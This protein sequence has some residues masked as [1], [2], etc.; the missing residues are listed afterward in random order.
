VKA[1]IIKAR[2]YIALLVVCVFLSVLLTPAYAANLDTL[3]KEKREKQQELRETKTQIKVQKKLE[4]NVLGELSQLDQ[5]IDAVERDLVG[6]RSKEQVASQAVDVSRKNLMNAEDRLRERTAILNVR[7]K[8]IFINGKVNYLEVLLSSRSFTQFI[9]RFEFLKRIIRQDTQL[10]NSIENERRDVANQKA[11]LELKLAEITDLEHRRTDQ[12]GVLKSQ[13]SDRQK[14]LDEIKTVEEAYKAAYE[15]LEQET[16]VL[17][18]LIRRK[19]GKS[20]IK[21]TGQLMWPIPEYTDISSTFG[22]RMHPIL[23]ERRMHYGVDFP[24]PSGTPVL[25]ADDGSVIF[26]GWM[27]GYG[28]VVVVDHGNGL[29]TTYSHLSSQNVKEG[30]NV[31]KGETLGGVGSTG[32]STG[33]HLDFSVRKD[34]NPVDP[35]G[36]L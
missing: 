15:E 30:Q 13:V 5:N 17:D 21:G 27:N 25:A 11:D 7:V 22:W 18:A 4:T 6:I 19:A 8:D 20:G 1:K 29:T 31:F 3:L 24:A 35:L 12:Q 28:K 32:L 14:K 2:S 16:K 26:V 36:Y 10:V 9:T 33:P 23:K 34:A